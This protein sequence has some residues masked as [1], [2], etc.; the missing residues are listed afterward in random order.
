M[1]RFCLFLAVTLFAGYSAS[2]QSY[3]VLPNEWNGF[4]SFSSQ[5][6]DCSISEHRLITK[7]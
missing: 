3:V 5:A 6:T 1:K 4:V 2:A 7:L